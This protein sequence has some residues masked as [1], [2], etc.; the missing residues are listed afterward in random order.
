M[1]FSPQMK[2]YYSAKLGYQTTFESLHKSLTIL[3]RGCQESELMDFMEKHERAELANDF[4]ILLELI[5][6]QFKLSMKQNP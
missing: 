5:N 2:T 4:L 6:L 3:F 1:D